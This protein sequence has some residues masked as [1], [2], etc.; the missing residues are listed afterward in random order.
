MPMAWISA[1]DEL[2]RSTVI[3]KD[4]QMVAAVLAEMPPARPAA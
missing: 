1:A 3:S 2:V 4:P